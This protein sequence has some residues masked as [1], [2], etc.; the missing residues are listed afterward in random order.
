MTLVETGRYRAI[1]TADSADALEQLVWTFSVVEGGNT[2]KYGNQSLIVD[3][4]AVDFTASD[5]TTLENIE[6]LVD[7]LEVRLGTPANLGGGATIAQNLADIESQT[8]DI[9]AAGAGLTAI[10]WNPAW[11]AEVQSEATDALV[12]Y[13]PPT[14]AEL[15]TAEANIRGVDNDT[16]KT[17]SDQID[18][19]STAAAPQLLQNTTIAT[20]TSQTVFTLTA[21]SADDDAYNGAIIII[22][23]QTT[24]TQ[25]AV[26]QISAYVGSTKQVT[27]S[28]DP[29]IFTMAVGDKVDILAAIGSAP[30]VVQ[31]RQEMDNNSTK[32]ADIVADTNELQSDWADGGRLDLILDARASQTSVNAVAGFVDDEIGTLLTMVGDLPTNAELATALAAADDAVLAA[33]AALNNLSAAQV[34]AEVVD[35]LNVDTYAEPGQ[36]APAATTSLAAKINY[37]YKAWRN[38]KRQSATAFELYNDAG[39]VVDQKATT[40]ESGGVTTVNEL[41]SGP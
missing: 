10:P 8:D 3:T 16:L 7:D 26:G 13:D 39:T 18:G 19:L 34:N 29:G 30:T 9:G 31:I 17:L 11:D 38:Q 23:D 40:L 32:L 15:D 37:L 27:L 20:L 28:A 36:G 5:R 1:Y 14:K 2:R 24:A 4:T 25:K 21:G 41:V 6:T 22:T 12:A 35:A 33:I